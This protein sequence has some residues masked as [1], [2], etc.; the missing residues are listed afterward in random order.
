M[1]KLS[2]KRGSDRDWTASVLLERAYRKSNSVGWLSDFIECT[3]SMLPC[4][5]CL[6][7]E[8]AGLTVN[9][10]GVNGRSYI[11][12]MLTPIEYTAF[13]PDQW[14]KAQ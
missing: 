8:H 5:Y 2:D 6:R 10:H 7:D 12:I 4:T 11:A 3:K 1:P 13:T 9:A 14:S